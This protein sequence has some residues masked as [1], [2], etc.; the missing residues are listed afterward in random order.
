MVLIWIG[1]HVD[2]WNDEGDDD[3]T[4][5]PARWLLPDATGAHAEVLA[6]PARR[7]MEGWFVRIVR[8]VRMRAVGS[9]G[10][11]WD[12]PCRHRQSMSER[13]RSMIDVSRS[14]YRMFGMDTSEIFLYPS[15]NFDPHING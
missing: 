4:P 5:P 2:A 8:E 6:M 14:R 12:L 10:C 15:K 13:E 7:R 9:I 1:R 3:I 11:L